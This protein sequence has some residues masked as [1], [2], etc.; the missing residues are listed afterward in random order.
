MVT[1]PDLQGLRQLHLE[2]AP[3]VPL[4]RAAAIR[5]VVLDPTDDDGNDLAL[6]EFTACD[7]PGGTGG[8]S[9]GGDGGSGSSTRR[10][11]PDPLSS[12][13]GGADAAPTGGRRVFRGG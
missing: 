13:A 6:G 12:V 7:L 3:P 10:H 9:G 1:I 8:G 4:M 5:P 11:P 2:R